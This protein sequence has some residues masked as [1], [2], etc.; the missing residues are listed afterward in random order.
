MTEIVHN[1]PRFE[2]TPDFESRAWPNCPAVEA[3]DVHRDFSMPFLLPSNI[4][5]LEAT[6][7]VG[8]TVEH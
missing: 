5:T 1:Y 6:S 7:G 3:S 2:D 8:L 4:R